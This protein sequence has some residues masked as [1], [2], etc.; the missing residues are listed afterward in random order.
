MKHIKLFEQFINESIKFKDLVDKKFDIEVGSGTTG[1]TWN[2]DDLT[3]E[4]ESGIKHNLFDAEFYYNWTRDGKEY[5][6][7]FDQDTIKPLLKNLD[8]TLNDMFTFK[9]N[10]LTFNI[11]GSES[12]AWIDNWFQTNKSI[13]K[14]LK[15]DYYDYREKYAGV[16]LK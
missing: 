6:K 7:V 8:K 3:Q 10:K 15:Q 11:E 13:S 9:G 14:S 4:I 1:K 16:K 2:E 12:E 5:L